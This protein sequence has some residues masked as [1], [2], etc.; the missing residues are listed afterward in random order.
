M[1]VPDMTLGCYFDK[2]LN[3]ELTGDNTRHYP[4]IMYLVK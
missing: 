1:G 3:L 4:H 2:S